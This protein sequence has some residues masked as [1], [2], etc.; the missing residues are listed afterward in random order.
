MYNK[1]KDFTK[2]V[3]I[4]SCSAETGEGINE[5]LAMLV[6]LSQKF[7]KQ[8]ISVKKQAKGVILEVKKEKSINYLESILYDGALNSDDKI[9]IASFDGVVV[10]K[11]RSMEQALPLNKGYKSAKKVEA[12]AGMRLQIISKEDILPGM[13][14]QVVK[15]EKEIE[16]IGKQFEKEISQEIRTGKTGILVKA[17]SLG[18]LEAVLV[19]LKQKQ[20]PI[21]NAGIGPITKK[22]IYTANS[23]HDEDKIILGF[24]VKVAEDAK[25]E[26]TKVKIIEREVIYKLIEDYE[27]WKQEKLR[28]IERAKLEE[29]P[30]LVKITIL[31]F[32]F[33]NS[34]PAVFGVRV[35]GGLLKQSI[36]LINKSNK[37]IGR[38]KTIQHEKENIQQA[39]TGKE[40]AI[41]VPGVNFERQL[42]VGESLYSNLSESQ[43]RKFKE[44][45]ELL[46]AD[47]KKVLM[48]IAEL[49]R[50][51]EVT[52][53][54]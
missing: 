11:I 45:K 7:L 26:K 43:F 25:E 39:E 24:N 30:S 5:I 28:E 6:A 4:I 47:E 46:S 21:I 50:K 22:D 33:R 14:F 36:E 1:I 49:K 51:E 12:A 27:E 32:V 8:K 29:L 3:A 13:P 18:S 52:W 23:L 41:S 53:G 44:H 20:I 48:E 15:S 34:N 35:D 54:V 19:L 16:Q 37:R 42:E 31:D 40:I 17:E 38:V 10:T 2:K 9:A